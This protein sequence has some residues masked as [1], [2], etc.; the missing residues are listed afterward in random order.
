MII[1]IKR[2]V[3]EEKY[4]ETNLKIQEKEEELVE[5]DLNLKTLYVLVR[6]LDEINEQSKHGLSHLEQ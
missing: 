5:I 6:N 3:N 4:E 1:K 2:C